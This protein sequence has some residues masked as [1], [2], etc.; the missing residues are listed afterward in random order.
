MSRCWAGM[1]QRLADSTD[2]SR[3]RHPFGKITDPANRL[4][5]GGSCPHAAN[6][7]IFLLPRSSAIGNI[8]RPYDVRGTL[9]ENFTL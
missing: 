1:H 7:G 8:D 4:T 3:W 5:G 2:R 6:A 9:P